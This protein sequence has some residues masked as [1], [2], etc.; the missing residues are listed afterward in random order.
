MSINRIIVDRK[1]YA[2]FVERFTDRVKS[3]IVGDPMD[4]TTT[5]GPLIN[6]KQVEKILK[7]VNESVEQGAKM[8]LEGN[9][10]G[11]KMEPFILTD[12]TNAM[13]IAQAEIFGPVAAIIPADNEEEAIQAANDTP[14]GLNGSVFSGSIDRGIRVANRI[15]TGMIHVNDSTINAETNTPFGGV[16]DSGLGRY[17]GDLI[18]LE[19]FTTIKWISVQHQ[20]LQYP[21]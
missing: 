5:I 8:V 2:T 18:T 6:R 14:Y 3:F 21:Y 16:K 15:K 1:I 17:H 7:L 12:V 19:E 9:V 4:E 11:N 13:A 20:P 10:N